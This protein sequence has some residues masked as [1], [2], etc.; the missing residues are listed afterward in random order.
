[1]GEVYL[2][3]EV[4]LGREVALK[5]LARSLSEDERF[6]ERFLRESRLAASLNHPNIVPVYRAGEANGV[7]FIAMHYVKGTDLR[8]LLGQYE[9]GL[10]T[11]RALSIVE[12]VAEALDAAHAHKLVHRDV[13]HGNILIATGRRRDHCYLADFGLTRHAS[14][15]SRLTATGEFLGTVEYVAPEQIRAEGEIDQRADVYS[16]GCVL[17][18]CLTGK[19]PFRGDSDYS[20]M[21]AHVH[22]PP[23]LLSE[24]REGLPGALDAVLEQALAKSPDDRYRTAGALAAA[25]RGALGHTGPG[26]RAAATRRGRRSPFR[27]PPGRVLWLGL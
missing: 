24:S 3:E 5:L 13:Q 18:E 23:P 27:R 7:L 4:G 2:A 25:T 17:F 15:Q 8:R 21:W 26:T 22:D 16:L 1:M 9:G 6:R 14:S 19:P 12:Q 11:E 20:V 10:D